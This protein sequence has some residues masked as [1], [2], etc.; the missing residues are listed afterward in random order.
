MD[1]GRDGGSEVRVGAVR[2]GGLKVVQGAKEMSQK[3][4][5]PHV[6]RFPLLPSFSRFL[7]TADLFTFPCAS[8]RK[9]RI[10]AEYKKFLIWLAV[11]NFE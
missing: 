8:P 3:L 11:A 7:L 9:I 2:G 5:L 10:K 4:F 1:A 6:F